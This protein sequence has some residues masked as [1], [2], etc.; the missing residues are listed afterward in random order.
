LEYK[1][2]ELMN[3]GDKLTM[4]K[5]A[6]L[7][8]YHHGGVSTRIAKRG[9]PSLSIRCA[10]NFR[11]RKYH[12]TPEDWVSSF[13]SSGTHIRDLKEY[14][15]HRFEPGEVLGELLHTGEDYIDVMIDSATFAPEVENPFKVP[16]AI[17]FDKHTTDAFTTL[18]EE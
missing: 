16:L 13:R 10:G 7:L 3:I 5:N 11:Y 2:E 9:T 12:K 17:K 4:K 8:R 14:G 1:K 18:Q 15:E 6:L